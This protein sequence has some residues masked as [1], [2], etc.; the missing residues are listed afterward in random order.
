MLLRES[1]GSKDPSYISLKET[2]GLP[3][4]NRWDAKGAKDLSYIADDFNAGYR[5]AQRGVWP[6]AERMGMA[7]GLAASAGV[8][9]WQCPSKIAPGSMIRQGV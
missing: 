3:D 6:A 8:G 4:T 1:P 9:M 7:M 5:T 2:S